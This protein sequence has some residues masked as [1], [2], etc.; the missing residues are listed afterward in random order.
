MR[1]RIVL[2]VCF[3]TASVVKK[4]SQRR[5][6]KFSDCMEDFLEALFSRTLFMETVDFQS[7]NFSNLGPAL[8]LILILLIVLLL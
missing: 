2:L 5:G 4:C 3:L 7:F 1:S 6:P 8:V